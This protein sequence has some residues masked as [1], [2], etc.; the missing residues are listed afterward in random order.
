VHLKALGI[1]GGFR[2]RKP[3]GRIPVPLAALPVEPVAD[4][5]L[6]LDGEAVTVDVVIV[7]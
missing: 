2:L 1:N 6:G 3:P 5:D 7:S 4:S